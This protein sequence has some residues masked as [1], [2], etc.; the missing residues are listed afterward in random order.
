MEKILNEAMAAARLA[1]Q[2]IKKLREDNNF[3]SYIKNGHELVTTADILSDNI[4]RAEL[5]KAYPNHKFI[6]EEG[7]TESDFKVQEPTWIID[8]IDG[9]VG[10]AN[11]HYQAA[12]SIAFAEEG[13]VKVGVVYNPFLEEMFYAMEGKGAFLNHNRIFASNV[14][15]LK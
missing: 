3:K 7:E 12:V 6:S 9:T 2:A 14:S 13:K 15:T 10:Y 8:P 5:S 1:G 4:I 11:N